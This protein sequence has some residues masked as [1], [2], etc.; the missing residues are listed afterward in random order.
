MSEVEHHCPHCGVSLTQWLKQIIARIRLRSRADHNRLFALIEKAIPQWP[1]NHEFQPRDA[2]HLRS[3]LLV[4]VGHINVKSIP[5]PDPKSCEEFPALKAIFRLTVES[6]GKAFEDDA[7]YV[8]YRVSSSGVEVVK[9]RSISERNGTVVGQKA[10]APIREAV[11]ALIEEVIGV[12]AEQL[13]RA[14]AA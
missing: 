8:D 1:E 12:P 9:A 14:R 13:L 5:Y 10:F 2:E 7:G 4:K 3:W 11:E 6:T